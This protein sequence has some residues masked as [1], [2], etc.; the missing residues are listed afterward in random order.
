MARV[1][2]TAAN[3]HFSMNNRY[4]K[5]VFQQVGVRVLASGKVV[6]QRVGVRVLA[7]GNVV[8]QRVVC[9]RKE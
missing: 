2:K 4:M 3:I 5:V 9:D 7:S 6:F 8:F 1:L